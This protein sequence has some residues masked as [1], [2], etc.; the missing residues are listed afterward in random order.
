MATS[1][2]APN[3]SFGTDA[4]GPLKGKTIKPI[5]AKGHLVNDTFLDAPAVMA[6]DIMYDVKSLR[7]G[8]KGDSNDHQ[9]GKINDLGMKAGGLAVAAY[10]FTK[11]PTPSTKW[12]EVVGFGTFFASMALWPKIALQAPAR[13]IHGFNIQQKYVDANG[14]KKDFYQDPQFIPWDLYTD[15][16]INKIGNRLNVP[17]NIPN[18]REFIQDKMKKIALQNNTMWMLTAGFATPVMAALL[19]NLTEKIVLKKQNEWNRA[20]V[21]KMVEGLDQPNGTNEFVEKQKQEF[22]ADKQAFEKIYESN[23]GK[24]LDETIIREISKTISPNMGS[25]SREHLAKD[26]EK[27]LLSSDGLINDKTLDTIINNINENIDNSF[28]EGTIADIYKEGLK[29]GVLTKEELIAFFSQDMT[30]NEHLSHKFPE[31][32][33]IGKDVFTGAQMRAIAE[34]LKDLTREKALN[35]GV[36]KKETIEGSSVREEIYKGVEEV[37]A[38]AAALKSGDLEKNIIKQRENFSAMC[39]DRLAS[40]TLSEIDGI[41]KASPARMFTEAE[42]T[43]LHSIEELLHPFGAKTAVHQ[44]WSRAIVGDAPEMIFGNAW[45]EMTSKTI[46]N[47]KFTKKE[48]ELLK[49]GGDIAKGVVRAKL[50]AITSSDE[51]YKTFMDSNAK[52]YKSF[53][54]KVKIDE[55]IEKNQKILD[56]TY[57]KGFIEKLRATGLNNLADHLTAESLGGIGSDKRLAETYLKERLEGVNT[58]LRMF[59]DVDVFRRIS[60]GNL[61]DVITTTP[62]SE[63][64]KDGN[65]IHWKNSEVEWGTKPALLEVQEELVESIVQMTF[66]TPSDHATKGCTPFRNNHPANETGTLIIDKGRVV[67][68]KRADGTIRDA[69]FAPGKIVK[70]VD[71]PNDYTFYQKGMKASYRASM[72]PDTVAILKKHG[73]LDLVQKYRENV[74]V[75]EGG[76]DYFA[77]LNHIVVDLTD[78]AKIVGKEATDAEKYNTVAS[79]IHEVVSKAANQLNNSKKWLKMFA[80]FGIGLVAVTVAAQFFFGRMTNPKKVQEGQKK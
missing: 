59:Q 20:K 51:A 31:R 18:R 44:S 54:E 16:Q 23:K 8:L 55:L 6:K 64:D 74:Y 45:K 69:K 78:E 12:M 22:K 11:R 80:G 41:F 60:T 47:F 66:W 38:K 79:A 7:C 30:K 67:G 36:L 5:Q 29:K 32:K 34:E 14:R 62:Y 48:L 4:V 10:L 73:I 65:F 76:A 37:A 15:K 58:F 33:V 77:K 35:G 17:K 13:L 24:P 25:I 2:V 53:V 9:L 75:K 27:I 63:L 70:G 42:K 71:I 57:N 26:L 39:R 40:C 52:A 61:G 3:T 50:E 28:S 46:E 1:S 19:C 49:H 21:D 43:A 72:H 56:A 68:A